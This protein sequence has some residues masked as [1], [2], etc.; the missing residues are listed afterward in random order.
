MK[1]M[2]QILKV[3]CEEEDVDMT[4]EAMELLTTIAF[5][6][7]L[8]YAMNMIITSSLAAR[9]RKSNTVG[10]EDVKKVYSL[11]ADVKRSTKVLN[12][13]AEEY[14]YSET[15]WSVCCGETDSLMSCPLKDRRQ[16]ILQH[17]K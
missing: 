7:S 3:R 17:S 13:D 5:N 6:T 10:E 14:L 4:E 2:R 15:K 9:K 8:R 12:E 1:E 16:S 11:F